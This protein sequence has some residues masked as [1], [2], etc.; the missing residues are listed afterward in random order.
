M[1]QLLLRELQHQYLLGLVGGGSTANS[2][3]GGNTINPVGSN[4]PVSP[5][6]STG[7]GGVT[8][9][10]P[11]PAIV[12]ATA[13]SVQLVTTRNAKILTKKMMNHNDIMEVYASFRGLQFSD[14]NLDFVKFIDSKIHELMDFEF[15]HLPEGEWRK[16]SSEDFF[17]FL[18]N[19]YQPDSQSADSS[20]EDRLRAIDIKLFGLQKAQMF[21][22]LVY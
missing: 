17:G 10:N 21:Q 9:T 3:Q 15:N 13:P 8:G 5:P 18:L 20:L 11:T 19:E 12:A 4:T 6:V 16:L 22:R 1:L 7:G 2:S 14:S